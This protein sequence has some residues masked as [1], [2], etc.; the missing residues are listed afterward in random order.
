LEDAMFL[1][2]QPKVAAELDNVK[3][4]KLSGG[5]SAFAF[6]C[7]L[8]IALLSCTAIVSFG[9]GTNGTLRGVV[10]D[11]RGGLVP[12]AAVTLSSVDRG[13]ERQTKTNSEGAYIFTAVAP[14]KFTL[15]VEA[16]NFKTTSSDVSVAP[17]ESVTLDVGLEVGAPTENVTITADVAQ[18]KTDTGERSDTLTAK[19]IDNLSIIGRSGLELL[20]ILPG[21]VGPDPGDPNSGVDRVT[22]GGGANATANYTV[23][24]IRGQNNNVSID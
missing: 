22:F 13:D 10:K 17:S 8:S 9:Q 2:G 14:G 24:G 5:A 23:N 11:P 20:R 12:N 7:L 21:V 3:R 6:H 16:A 1:K 18:I 15:K 4:V 19:Q